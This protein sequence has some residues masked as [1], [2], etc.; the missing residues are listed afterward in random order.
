MVVEHPQKIS[1]ASMMHRQQ[2]DIE[3]AS[4]SVLGASEPESELESEL[5]LNYYH[6]VNEVWHFCSVDW[7]SRCKTLECG[8]AIEGLTI[9]DICV[10]YNSICNPQPDDL[11]LADEEKKSH[12]GDK[13]LG[14]RYWTWLIMC[15]DGSLH[16]FAHNL[17]TA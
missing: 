2:D 14:V 9:S 6:L 3:M 10:G 11:S 16:L 8:I 17:R 1:L 4:P 5:N 7:G 12:L 13:P 15:N